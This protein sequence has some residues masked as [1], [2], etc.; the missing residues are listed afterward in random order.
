M[1]KTEQLFHKRDGKNEKNYNQIMSGDGFSTDPKTI[2]QS[3][4]PHVASRILNTQ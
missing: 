4:I 2:G 3:D 1:R